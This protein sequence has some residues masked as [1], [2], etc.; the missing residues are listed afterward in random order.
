MAKSQDLS[1]EATLTIL[2][3]MLALRFSSG[4]ISH[5]LIY[6]GTTEIPRAWNPSQLLPTSGAL[7]YSYVKWEASSHLTSKRAG[8]IKIIPGLL[9][10]CKALL[11]LFSSS[12]AVLRAR[13]KQKG[14]WTE[15]TCIVST[16][17]TLL[18][19]PC[20]ANK[21]N[22]ELGIVLQAC[23]PSTWKAKAGGLEIQGK[24]PLPIE[25]KAL[26]IQKPFH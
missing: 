21:N 8:G 16:R 5:P 2:S 4:G 3:S 15:L 1:Q 24:P 22:K 13:Q 25:F 6:C 14:L 18:S 26:R 11:F 17:K 9:L 7:V 23:D 10:I 19:I 12:R 20:T